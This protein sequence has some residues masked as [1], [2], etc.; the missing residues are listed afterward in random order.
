MA[1]NKTANQLRR[2]ALEGVHKRVELPKVRQGDPSKVVVP[3]VLNAPKNV[4]RQRLG[5]MD[6][7]A[8]EASEFVSRVVDKD[9]LP[10]GIRMQYKPERNH[11]WKGEV[12]VNID[13]S[14]RVMA[15]EI[16]HDIEFKHSGV[17]AKTRAF[18]N[19]RAGGQ[20][21]KKLSKLTG[22]KGYKPHE[23]AFEDE[24]AKRGGS[25]YMGKDY[26][27]WYEATELLT[28]GVERLMFDPVSFARQDP[29]YFEFLLEVFQT[30]GL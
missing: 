3:G 26:S 15:H 14:T 10:Q 6:T 1:S 5:Y 12:F 19:K 27:Q 8:T 20:P 30:P 2:E 22:D 9:Y 29:E 23:I 7:T 21:T 17:A 4:N 16:I 11:Y 18:L 13:T 25:H 24:W 28:M